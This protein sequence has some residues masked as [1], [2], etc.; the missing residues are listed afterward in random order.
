MNNFYE[1]KHNL[2]YFTLFVFFVYILYGLRSYLGVAFVLAYFVSFLSFSKLKIFIYTIL[3]FILLFLAN[4]WGLFNSVLEYRESFSQYGEN[5]GGSNIDLD[6]SNPKMFIPNFILSFAYQNLGFF[7]PNFSS[8]ILFLIECI[9]F[10]FMMFFILKNYKD[11]FLVRF[12]L[13]FSLIYAA[14]WCISN[15]NLGTA[16]RLRLFNYFAVYI[17]FLIL[18]KNKCK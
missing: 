11:S 3:G 8:I 16:V 10:I 17:C 14:M 5:A 1:N 4:S 7:F 13:I 15:A 9:P 6:F 18:L 2:I 12:L